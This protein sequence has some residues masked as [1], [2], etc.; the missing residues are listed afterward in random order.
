MI[1][2]TLFRWIHSAQKKKIIED[3]KTWRDENWLEARL[4]AQLHGIAPLLF[5]LLNKEGALDYIDP[6]LRKYLSEQF[7][8][9]KERIKIITSELDS[10][11]EAANTKGVKVMPLKG[12]ILTNRYYQDPALRPMADIDLLV[13]SQ[14]EDSSVEVLNQKGYKQTS[15]TPYY[16]IFSSKK[17][18]DSDIY[19]D[20]EHPENPINI[21]LR[22]ELVFDMSGVYCDITEYIWNASDDGFYGYPH[23]MSLPP[24]ALLLHLI[25]HASKHLYKA[26]FRAIQLVDLV[27]VAQ[28][29]N[30]GDWQELAEVARSKRIERFIYAPLVLAERY[31]H[32][33]TPPAVMS[34]L[35]ENTPKYL[36]KYV[37][38]AKLE[39]LCINL[40][41]H[42]LCFELNHSHSLKDKLLVKYYK[43]VIKENLYFHIKPKWIDER[44]ELKRFL[45]SII[46]PRPA[47]LRLWYPG[48][49][50][51]YTFLM[52]YF[53]HALMLIFYPIIKLL[54]LS[55]CPRVIWK[56]L[57]QRIRRQ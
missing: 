33:S 43:F 19:L 53:I 14:D 3:I 13:P 28:K 42:L 29:F 35:S 39:E 15:V 26:V 57:K 30:D 24:S 52:G 12:S 22:S 25:C 27:L 2:E 46:F 17:Y 31:M 41:F 49:T 10:I 7:T 34:K 18:N 48:L 55:R 38:G 4:I 5:S 9:N 36:R 1:S 20:G 44:K 37:Q 6:I 11:L 8:L 54:E 45:L 47:D 40:G 21:D 51:K 32:L 50:S 23:A 16:K 56:L